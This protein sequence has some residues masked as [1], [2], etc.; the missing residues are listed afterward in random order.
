M[1]NGQ[2]IFIPEVTSTNDYLSFIIRERK[3][4]GI[5]TEDFTTVYTDQQTAGR[6]QAGNRWESNSKENILASFYFN[7]PISPRKQFYINIFFSLAV[8]KMLSKYLYDVKI[9][10]PND[11]Y[12]GQKKI[13]G[14]L[15]EHTLQGNQITQTIAGVGINLNQTSF[16]ALLPNPTSVKLES[17][18]ENGR[19]TLLKELTVIAEN[20]YELLRNEQYELLL[21]EYYRYLF[22]IGEEHFFIIRGEKLGATITGLDEYGQLQLLLTDGQRVTCGFKEVEWVL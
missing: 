6:G 17:G 9:K 19:I 1:N 21:R 14:I 12:V 5:N 4:K 7:L 13:A 18:H 2:F 22:R 8:R 11:I 15:I 16:S 3:S 20:Y 10:W